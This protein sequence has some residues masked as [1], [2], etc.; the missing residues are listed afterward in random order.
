MPWS[1]CERSNDEHPSRY[2]GGWWHTQGSSLPMNGGNQHRSLSKSSNS[3]AANR[4]ICISRVQSSDLEFCCLWCS[5]DAESFLTEM[6][7]VTIQKGLYHKVHLKQS[8][9]NKEIDKGWSVAPEE[10][11]SVPRVFGFLIGSTSYQLCPLTLFWGWS[12]HFFKTFPLI[13]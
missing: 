12:N 1:I 13:H 7:N 8:I 2:R 9:A 3:H 5:E 4:K 11:F 10:L 6:V